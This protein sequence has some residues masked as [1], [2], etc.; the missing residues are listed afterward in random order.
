MGKGEK[1]MGGEDIFKHRSSNAEL[2]ATTAKSLLHH[3][4]SSLTSD[5]K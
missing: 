3:P 4:S 5:L 2:H 1:E